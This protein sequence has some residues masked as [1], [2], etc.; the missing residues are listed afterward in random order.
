[1]QRELYQKREF[2]N[3]LRQRVNLLLEENKILKAG[4]TGVSDEQQE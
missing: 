4:M 3:E 2:I 1:L